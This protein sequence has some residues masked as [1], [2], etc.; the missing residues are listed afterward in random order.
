MAT[1]PSSEAQQVEDAL[2]ADRVWHFAGKS[3]LSSGWGD[4]RCGVWLPKS[5]WQYRRQHLDR[6]WCL[7]C[8]A[9]L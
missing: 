1:P 5:Y 9:T 4:T 6:D 3:D 2:L 7:N 8:R